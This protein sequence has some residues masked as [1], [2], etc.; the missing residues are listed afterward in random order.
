MAEAGGRSAKQKL[1]GKRDKRRKWKC[2]G[3]IK[4]EGK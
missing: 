3:G 2:R 1:E 4:D